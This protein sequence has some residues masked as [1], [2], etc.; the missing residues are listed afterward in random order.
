MLYYIWVMKMASRYK[1]SD[2]EIKAIEQARKENKGNTAQMQ[3]Y[4]LPDSHFVESNRITP[5][6]CSQKR[7][8]SSRQ[9]GSVSQ[10]QIC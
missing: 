1:F 10:N 6:F 9:T 7:T 8:N 2:E 5:Y 4:A 3:R